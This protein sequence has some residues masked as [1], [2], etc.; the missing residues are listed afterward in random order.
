MMDR[1]RMNSDLAFARQ[2]V[3]EQKKH[4]SMLLENMETMRILRHD[5]SD[6]YTALCSVCKAKR[7]PINTS[8]N[9]RISTGCRPTAGYV[10]TSLSTI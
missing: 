9:F 6:A 7:L 1:Q 3:K 2:I 8:Q 5:L 10:K 4:Y